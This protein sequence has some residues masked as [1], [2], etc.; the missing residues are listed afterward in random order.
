MKNSELNENVTP[1]DIGG[2]GPI[3]LPQGDLIGSGDIPCDICDE[4]C[5]KKKKVYIKTF[6]QFINETL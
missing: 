2:M 1:S 3:V 5:I 4:E 6:E